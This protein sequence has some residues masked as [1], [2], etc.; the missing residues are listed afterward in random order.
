MGS[1]LERR[2]DRI[3][4]DPAR[5]A[6]D[7]AERP[8]RVYE[9][10]QRMTRMARGGVVVA[11]V[12]VVV[13]VAS[14]SGAASTT[15]RAAAPHFLNGAGHDRHRGAHGE[16][17]AAV[18]SAVVGPGVARCQAR[19]R[20]DLLGD[21]VAPNPPGAA[22]SRDTGR[23][24]V[25]GNQGAY[26]PAYLR[27]AYNAPLGGGA[28]QTVAIVDA[29]DAPN[30]E[31][32]LATYRSFFG[33]P[34]CTT[35]NGCFTKLDQ[36]GG[37]HYPASDASWETETTLDAQMVS[38]ICPS[39][40]I[41]VVE[42][43][44]AL[45]ANL[46]RSVAT[47]VAHG[48]DVVSNSYGAGE[49]DGEDQFRGL[50][51]H[52]GVAIVAA[53]G[54][55]GFGVEFPASMP[56]TVAVG[57]TTLFQST[58]TGTRD[59]TETAWQDAGSGCSTYEAK[60]AWQADTGCAMRS[61]SDVAAVADPSTGV[62]VFN[63]DDGGWEVF[64]GT[65]VAA[66]IIAAFYALASNSPS[67]DDVVAYPYAHAAS[68]NDVTS[69][70][71]GNCGT[72]LCDATTGYDGPTGLGTPNTAAAFTASGVVPPPV[73]VPPPTPPDF[74]VN[75][76]NLSAPMRP[77]TTAKSTV[78]IAPVAG[79]NGPISLE[80][81]V[82]PHDG[83]SASIRRD[84][85]SVGSTPVTTP[86]TLRA[87][88]GGTY[89]VTVFGFEGDLSHQR[90]ITVYVNDFSMR[91]TPKRVTV[92]RGQRARF[93]IVFKAMGSLTGPIKLAAAGRLAKSV[94]YSRVPA[95]ASGSVTV[96]VGTAKQDAPGLVTLRFTAVRGALKHS[97][98][99]TL[100]LR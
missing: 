52:P 92:T 3:D 17:D 30:L 68:L 44:N 90:T 4:L 35:A 37:T 43:T 13:A 76:T 96:T 21:D 6:A 74:T 60:P 33:L 49:F 57:G 12:A 46:G 31:S 86:L 93:A 69:G 16:V 95:P 58:N 50:Y 97:V 63:Q 59:A 18:C 38:A 42:A 5:G 41:L 51:E 8:V 1:R 55:T 89:R 27:S 72:Y 47:A 10:G 32:D 34:S 53:T 19:A 75:A 36:N 25:L 20:T 91:S 80:T 73:D 87:Y 82:S 62:W 64:G 29:F 66:P 15:T 98:V 14:T 23:A 61:V 24:D 45:I 40:R 81:S 71:N 88:S 26:D 22:A 2:Y 9:R 83:L 70:S 79:I 77:G 28:G 84:P 99:V 48:A 54:D 85:V 67:T 56:T 11:L 100:L 7:E 39:C 65:S 94:A 78:T